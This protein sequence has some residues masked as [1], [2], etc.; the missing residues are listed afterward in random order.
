[1]REK[2]SDGGR[3]R[4]VEARIGKALEREIVGGMVLALGGATG[5][6]AWQI[7]HA[8]YQALHSPRGSPVLRRV[9]LP[10]DRADRSAA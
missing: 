5:K 7:D 9:G 10:A 6:V 3:R 1:M 8:A 4:A 2:P